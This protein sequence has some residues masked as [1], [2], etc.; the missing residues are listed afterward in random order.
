M[1]S[2][3]PFGALPDDTAEYM[4]GDVLVTVVLMESSENVTNF[5]D[6]SEDWT[7]QSIAVVKEKAVEGVSWWE[8][9][10]AAEFPQAA[11]SLN[12]QFDFTYADNPVSTDYE[13]ISQISNYFQYWMYDFLNAVDHGSTGN[14]SEDIRSFNDAQ[15]VT[16]GTNWAFTIFVVNDENDS[17]G[18]FKSGGS[19][20]RAFSFAGGQFVVTPA[21][22]PASTFAHETGHMFWARDEYSGGGSYTDH[23]GYYDTYNDNAWDNPAPGFVQSESLM[24][25]G[26]LLTNAY[27]SHTSSTSSLEMIGWRDTDG[28]GIFDVLDVPHTLTGAGSYDPQQGVYHFTGSSSVQTLWNQNPSG[29]QSDITLNRITDAQYRI[30]GG[31][32]N[33]ADSYDDYQVGLDL[34][35]PVPSGLHTIEIRTLDVLTG[36]ASNVFQGDTLRPSSVLNQGINGFAWQDTDD[37]GQRETGEPPLSGWTVRLVNASGEPLQLVETVEPDDYSNYAVLTNVHPEVTLTLAGDYAAGDVIVVPRGSGRVFGNTFGTTWTPSS[38]ELRMDFTTPVT[39]VRLDAIGA[40]DGSYARMEIYDENDNLLGRYTTDALGWGVSETMTLE[41]PTADIAYAIAR[42]HV[43]TGVA[44]DSLQFG[45]EA[46]TQTDDLGAYSIAYLPE[47]TYYVQALSPTGE[48]AH[49]GQQT[50][51][52]GEGEALSEIDFASDL[53]EVSWRNDEYPA[54]VTGDGY[55]LPVDALLLINYINANMGSAAVPPLPATP[56]PYYD[57]NGDN[58]V[59]AEDVL[60]VINELNAAAAGGYPGS[61]PEG[62]LSPSVTGAEGEEGRT[63]PFASNSSSEHRDFAGISRVAAD[64]LDRLADAIRSDKVRPARPVIERHADRANRIARAFS[65]C[66]ATHGDE[67]HAGLEDILSQFAHDVARTHLRAW[68]AIA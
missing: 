50:A 16:H 65:D 58:F 19:F 20:R 8:D 18:L 24:T 30:D 31:N 2:A 7:P 13:P 60:I 27:A 33:S 45:P 47:G 51:V 64:R 4:L 29:L 23:R 36:V 62:E 26:T 11:G 9:T 44:L 1:L 25:A 56:P 21:G 66:I 61:A 41:Y 34:Q 39:S 49:S 12:F 53:T 5:N 17:D 14:F 32:W 63:W 67:L 10:L 38:A 3:T 40:A 57:V 54:D 37:D 68:D 28:D 48:P 15:R 55:V 43:G 46:S 35:F 22:R 6:N 52:L 59:T 42:G